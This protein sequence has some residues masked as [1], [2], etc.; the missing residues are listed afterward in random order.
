MIPKKADT[1]MNAAKTASSAII[2]FERPRIKAI[3]TWYILYFKI[4]NPE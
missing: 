2:K 1:S 3:P 4:T